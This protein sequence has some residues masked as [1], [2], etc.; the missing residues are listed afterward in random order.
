M[1]FPIFLLERS[2][3]ILT[4]TLIGEQREVGAVGLNVYT[5]YMRMAGIGNVLMVMFMQLCFAGCA[6]AVSWYDLNRFRGRVG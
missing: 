5:F 2:T 3:I 4:L 6:V 1:V